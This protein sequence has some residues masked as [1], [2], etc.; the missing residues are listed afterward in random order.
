M[1]ET[2]PEKLKRLQA[3]PLSEKV[4]LSKHLISEWHDAWDGDVSASFSGG[5]DSTVLL[6]LTR[7]IYPDMPAVFCNTGLEY[8]E[9]LSFVKKHRNIKWVRPKLRFREVIKKYGYPVVSKENSQKLS[10]IRSTR[11]EKLL[12]KRLYGDNNKYRSGKLPN[13]WHFLINA[14]FKI[15][16][17]CCHYLKKQPMKK[18]TNIYLGNMSEDSHARRQRYIRNNGCGQ[19]FNSNTPQS[20]PL[21][22]WTE[23]NV[24]EYI[25]INNIPYSKIYDMGYDRTGC[26]FCMFGLHLEKY[27]NRFQKMK[28]THPKHW[29]YCIYRL[30]LKTPLDF[31]GIPYEPDKHPQI[32]IF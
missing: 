7:S 17:K 30:D 10:Q 11:S 26:M 20:H 23:E 24:W 25:K 31:M 22:F 18:F 21:Y 14:P 2:P 32:S 3:L 6:S 19:I 5:I 13:K 28:I 8:P 1:T 4:E 16:E 9:I 27:P 12:H 15:S 29:E